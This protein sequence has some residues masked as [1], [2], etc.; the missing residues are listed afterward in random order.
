[1][2]NAFIWTSEIDQYFL[3]LP[4]LVNAFLGVLA[5]GLWQNKK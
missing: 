5:I 3:I 4:I 2:L 1:M